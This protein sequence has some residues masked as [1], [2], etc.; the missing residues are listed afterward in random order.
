[1]DFYKRSMM[2]MSMEM[3]SD[4]QLCDFLPKFAFPLNTALLI[5]NGW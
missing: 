5:G 4:Q 2:T 3:Q 1:M